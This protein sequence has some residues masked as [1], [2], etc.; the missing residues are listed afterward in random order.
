MDSVEKAEKTV[1]KL[2]AGMG[3]YVDSATSSD[4]A[5]EHPSISLTLR[6]PVGAFDQALDRFETLGVRLSKTIG[7]E[8]VTSQIVDLEARL[9]TMTATEETYRGLLRQTHQL[10]NVIELQDKLTEV[11]S[12]IESMAAQ[13]KALSGLAS[14]S[15]VTLTLQQ[16]AV[17]A[18]A[19][20]DPNWLAQTWGESTSRLGGLMRSAAA[21]G[22]WAVVF[23][24]LWAPVLWL[25]RR[26]Y[27]AAKPAVRVVP[28]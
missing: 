11:R 7:S 21:I 12:Q 24:P 6:V 4:L 23:S 9:K 1:D 27:R 13:R 14:L 28:Q 8:D 5:S 16:S 18:Q 15:T 10:Q 19:P 25:L 26:S 2:V 3:G 20:A 22:I 17:P